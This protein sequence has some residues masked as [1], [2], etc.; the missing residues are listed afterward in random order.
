MKALVLLVLL[1]SCYSA[2]L[3]D[4]PLWGDPCEVER[5]RPE[6]TLHACH[7]TGDAYQIGV[8]QEVEQGD[9]IGACRPFCGPSRDCPPGGRPTRGP[10]G[11]CYCA[12]DGR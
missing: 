2:D 1:A 10:L 11:A 4:G 3:Y 7:W 8:C 12:S 9:D 5:V 6:V